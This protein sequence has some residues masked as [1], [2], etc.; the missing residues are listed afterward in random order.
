M[1]LFFVNELFQ[2]ITK[3]I[4]VRCNALHNFERKL[5]NLEFIYFDK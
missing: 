2:F 5:Y 4:L 1:V 3:L